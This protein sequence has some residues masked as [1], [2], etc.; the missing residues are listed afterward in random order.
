MQED[1]H[2]ELEPD[3][4]QF[5]SFRVVGDDYAVD[6]LRVQEIRGWEKVRLLPDSQDYLKGVL[7]LRGVMVPIVDLRMRFGAT[8]PEYAATTVVI[9]V[10]LSAE[11]G[12]ARLVGIVVDS[13]SDVLE[14]L[15]EQVKAA[16]T[17]GALAGRRY[18]DGIVSL[19]RGMVLLLDLDKLFEESDWV[20]AGNGV[21][22]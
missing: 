20:V 4:S 6:I 2:V 10:S 7:D 5:L 18:V 15:T 1:R 21:A 16:P 8:Q 3:S 11:A 19:P 13:V 17:L 12:G 14:I 9:V 22:R